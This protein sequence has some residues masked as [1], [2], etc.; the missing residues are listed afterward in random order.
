LIYD[1]SNQGYVG[2]QVGHIAKYGAPMYNSGGPLQL[3]PPT[4]GPGPIMN[5]TPAPVP[6]PIDN[7]AQLIH[8]HTNVLRQ[9]LYAAH[10][11]RGLAPQTVSENGQ[12]L[13]NPLDIVRQTRATGSQNLAALLAKFHG[14]PGLKPGRSLDPG[15]T[16]PD[17]G[18]YD[19]GGG[20][21]QPGGFEAR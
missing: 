8:D 18:T 21:R 10:V 2:P 3:L 16:R 9:R 19:I 17:F 11:Q 6:A 13:A 12:A 1:N 15:F 5:G 14:L 4:A 7:V 20:F